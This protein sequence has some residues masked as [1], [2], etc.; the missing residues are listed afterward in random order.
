MK[1]SILKKLLEGATVETEHTKD[2]GTA[3]KIAMDHLKEDVD[4]YKKLKKV[5]TKQKPLL[6]EMM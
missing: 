5:E 1:E 6:K 2:A 3:L 4:Y